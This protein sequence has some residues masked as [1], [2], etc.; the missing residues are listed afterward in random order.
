MTHVANVTIDSTEVAADL[1]DYPVYVDLSDLPASFWD[2][3]ASGGGD[4]R[5]YKSDG[6]TELAREVVS[7]EV[8]YQTFDGVDDYALA[9]GISPNVANDFS[10]TMRYRSP[11][12]SA[13]NW[14]IPSQKI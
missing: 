5:C 14:L 8:A 6:T 13:R 1:T 10:I 7:C 9:T 4:I 3:V 12:L 11:P 2:T